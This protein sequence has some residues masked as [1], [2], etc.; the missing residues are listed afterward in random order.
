MII[1]FNKIIAIVAILC[2][3]FIFSKTITA[4]NFTAAPK[5][6]TI[7]YAPMSN[8]FSAWDAIGGANNNL[9]GD[10]IATVSD[11][12]IS[13]SLNRTTAAIGDNVVITLTATNNGPDNNTNISV[14][15]LLPAGYT[16]L[17]S[18][19]TKG[20][21]N[22][23]NGVWTIGNLNNGVG[24]T[25]TINASVNST[26]S[27]VNSAVI[28]TTS[29]ITDPNTTNN[30]STT[31]LTVV[32]TEQVAG[33]D[34]SARDGVSTTFS[35]PAT[36]NGF[37][38]DIYTLDNSFNM[39]INGFNLTTKEIEFQ[40]SGTSGINIKF[41][42]GSQYE[43]GG[44]GTIYSFNG[45]PAKPMIRVVISA[46]GVVSIFGSKTTNGPLFPLTLFNGNAFN[47]VNWNTSGTNTIVVSQSVVGPTYITG[48]GY[49]SN[50]I[51][52]VCY[53]PSTNTSAGIDTKHGITLLQRAGSNTSNW[54]MV[55]KSA[56]IVL[57]SNTKGFVITR[58][59]KADLGNITDP[60]EG[61]LVYDTTDKCL[62][63]YD[64]NAWSCF[65]KPA[66]PR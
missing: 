32:C 5:N 44:I 24:A 36:N 26:G 28:S 16:I 21:Y 56:F 45:S 65:D 34:F 11:L 49:G 8:A 35:E 12:S 60:Q 51:P 43:A 10:R 66:C 54:P 3:G 39:K 7:S 23:T 61:M 38:F 62:K 2:F 19:P 52:C 40:S 53:N 50:I 58:I 18:T 15:D 59:A 55:R 46:S 29:N 6:P 57:E 25:L 1:K 13:Q 42:D 17:G 14:S 41:T 22:S 31:S 27:N 48:R 4:F 63:A 30:K 37:V 64:G 47:A 33:A 9:G 20:T